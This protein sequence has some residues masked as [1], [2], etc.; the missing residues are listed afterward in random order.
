MIIRIYPQNP[1]EKA[2]AQ[3]VG[4]LER[5]GVII[6]P[7]DGV[8][9][10]GCSLR[11]P[12]AIEKL[13]NITGKEGDDLA[14]V[15]PDLS[16]IATY[17]K[18]DTPVFKILKRNLPGPFTFILNASGK[19]PDKFLERRKTIGVRVPDNAIPL[20]IVRALGCPLITSSVK[21]PGS[22][23]ETEYTTDPS[24]IHERYESLVDA[25]VDG[26]YGNVLPTT[27]VDCTSDEPVILRE[28][29]GELVL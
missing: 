17:A 11:S 15:C 8:Y 13:R 1:N 3:V 7:T 20:E 6:Y 29:I 23:G 21:E 26:G 22:G 28:G 24:L 5:D 4:I 14:I 16:L 18:V 2:I 27:V 9:A 10:F 25:V 19:V 12:R